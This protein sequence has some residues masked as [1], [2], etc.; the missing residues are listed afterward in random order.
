MDLE[1]KWRQVVVSTCVCICSNNSNSLT[2]SYLASSKRDTP[3]P[4]MGGLGT[5]PLSLPQISGISLKD[6][7]TINMHYIR[8]K[9]PRVVL[10]ASRLWVGGACTGTPTSK[11]PTH[12]QPHERRTQS[13]ATMQAVT[14]TCWGYKCGHKPVGATGMSLHGQATSWG[15][16]W[17]LTVPSKLST[18]PVDKKAG[19]PENTHGHLRVSQLGS[20]PCLLPAL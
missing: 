14:H 20:E 8:K 1:P 4:G 16:W 11:L 5:L 12:G 18:T 6:L 13:W 9:R 15:C 7:P 3:A 10:L 17:Q 2:Y 19:R